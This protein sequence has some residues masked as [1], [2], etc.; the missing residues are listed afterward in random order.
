MKRPLGWI[1]SCVLA[2]VS[3]EGVA[4]AQAKGFDLDRY[5]PA[6]RGSDWF[7]LESL[8]L[9]GSLR[10][11][12]GITGDFA[13]RPL[14]L[15]TPS[16]NVAH[17]VVENQDFV[18]LGASLVLWERLRLGLNVP[19]AVYENGQAGTVNGTTFQP[20]SGAAIGD[21]RLGAD[22]RLVGTYG[23]PF[24]LALGAQLFLP[25]GKESAFT[26]DGD[27]RVEPRLLAAG[28]IGPF[29]YAAKVA[30]DYRPLTGDVAGGTLGSDLIFGA[31][32]G[33]KVLRSRLVLGP[34]LF[35]ST[36]TSQPFKIQ[37][38][39]LEIIF[40]GH[41]SLGSGFRVGAGVDPGLSRG[42]GAPAVRALVSIEWFPDPTA[43]DRDKDGIPDAED[44]CPDTPGVRTSDPKTNGCPPALPDRDRDGIPDESD[45]CPDIPGVANPDPKKN[46][47][48][49]DRD[50]DGIPDAVDACPDVAGVGNPDP[51]KN[52]CP[53]DRDGDGIPDSIDACPD[54]PGVTSPDPKKNGC[55]PDRDNDGIPDAVDACPDVAG[56]PNADPAKNGCPLAVVNKGQIEILEQIK[57]RFNSAELDP[58]SDP[59]LDAVLKILNEHSEIRSVRIEGHTDNV[60]TAAYNRDLS[61]RR[62]G[63]VLGWLVSHGIDK[64]RLTSEGFG[65]KK[66]LAPNATEEGR[67]QNRRV[68]F[69]I[70]EKKAP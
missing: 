2:F 58:A 22:V 45:A 8:D 39:P 38:S 4:R 18:H 37:D 20:P 3:S 21:V 33:F 55:P 51:K 24:T 9:Q 44:A 59:I 43:P 27:V 28:Q 34:E 69:H 66:P 60:G 15:Y 36:V 16:G 32:A 11:A 62:A 67:R 63:S 52:G 40:G 7:A 19:I 26:G 48:P 42:F 53:P 64:G 68:E 47:C 61:G 70:V 41:A 25:T 6:E 35:G 10:P 46:G 5:D 29:V 54:V 56:P 14:V 17:S 50:N 30:F 65:L 31:A 57:F 49:P 23:G 13:Y 1:L 12:V